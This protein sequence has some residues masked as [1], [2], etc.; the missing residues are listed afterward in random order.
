QVASRIIHVVPAQRMLTIH[1]EVKPILE[2]GEKAIL[3]LEVNRKEPVD[4]IVSV[5]DKALRNIAP[6]Q[7]TDIR[8]FY[9][10]D[11]RIYQSHAREV[12]RRRLG[13]MTLDDLLKQDSV[14]LKQHPEKRLT[15]E[16]AAL[17]VL[18]ASP[19]AARPRTPEVAALL[20]LAGIKTRAVDVLH[21]WP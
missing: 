20:R 21:H 14:W 5:Y 12:L 1:S 10:A 16:S 11:D 4:L 19:G 18:A 2:P 8:N 13:E 3:N 9:L 7:S 17:N 15:P 6:D